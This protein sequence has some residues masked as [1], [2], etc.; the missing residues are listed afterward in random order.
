M[1]ASHVILN[2]TDPT[3]EELLLAAAIAAHHSDASASGNVPVDYT[4]VRHVKKPS[5]ARPGFVNYFHQ[6]TL[7]VTPVND[8]I[9][10]YRIE[11]EP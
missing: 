10:P 7:Y 3:R 8:A 2:S 9:A 1:P 4:R 6:H 11:E 5:G